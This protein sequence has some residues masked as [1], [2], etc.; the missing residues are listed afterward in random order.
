MYGRNINE[1]KSMNKKF[2]ELTKSLVQSGTRRAALKK[3][4][5]GVL[6]LAGL[7]AMPTAARAAML[8]PLIE[9]SRPNAVGTCESG[10]VSLPG[11]WTLDEALEQVGVGNP[12]N[13][14]NIVAAWIQLSLETQNAVECVERTRI[15]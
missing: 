3:F 7:L 9:L 6:A 2:E 13:P 8:G 14:K 5:L 10:F 15:L 1:G 4:G 11:T 12:V